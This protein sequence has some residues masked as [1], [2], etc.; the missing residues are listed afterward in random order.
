ME[1]LFRAY[2]TK[3]RDI[4]NRQT[5]L[6]VVAEAGLD[7]RLAEAMLN[8]EEGLDTIKEAGEQSRRLQVDS[9]P[10]FVVN[11]E[12]T[13]SGAQSPNVFLAAFNQAIGSQ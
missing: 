10:Y 3:G 5:L 12:I 2:F 9:V 8:S 6:D 4:S 11:G 1:A 13:L 7:R